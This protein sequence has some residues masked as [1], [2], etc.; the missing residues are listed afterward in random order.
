MKLKYLSMEF[1][2]KRLRDLHYD[3]INKRLIIYNESDPGIIV[4]DLTSII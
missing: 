2:G 3:E 4:L 1:D